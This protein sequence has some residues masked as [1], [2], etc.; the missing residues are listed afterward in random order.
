MVKLTKF[1]LCC[2]GV[3]YGNSNVVQNIFDFDIYRTCVIKF[4]SYFSRIVSTLPVY[5]N[6]NTKI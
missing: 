1:I 6:F 5:L 3:T 2:V 4:F